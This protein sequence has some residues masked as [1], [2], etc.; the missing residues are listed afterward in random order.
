M[1]KLFTEVWAGIKNPIRSF[2]KA[3]TTPSPAD[4]QEEM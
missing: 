2:E 3:V 1:K 4:A